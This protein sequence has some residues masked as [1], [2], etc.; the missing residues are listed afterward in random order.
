MRRRWRAGGAGRTIFVRGPE[1]AG[2][3]IFVRGHKGPNRPPGRPKQAPFT[4]PHE[5]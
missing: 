4:F 2:R 1:A 3:T 5:L